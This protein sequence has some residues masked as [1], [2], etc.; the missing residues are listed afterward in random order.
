VVAGEPL[1]SERIAGQRL[2][3]DQRRRSPVH[4]LP[5]LD[6]HR[7]L[8]PRQ[9]TEGIAFACKPIADHLNNKVR[10]LCRTAFYGPV[11]LASSALT[12]AGE[13]PGKPCSYQ[14]L[15][16]AYA[17]FAIGT[18]GL[19]AQQHA[20][21]F[22]SEFASRYPDYYAPEVFGDAAHMQARAV[23]YF[24]PGQAAVIFPG[25]PP[26]TSERLAALGRVIGPQF[27]RQQ[28]R[29]MRTFTDFTCDTTV[30]FGVSLMMFDGHPT[31]FGGK[32][33]LLFGVDIIALLHDPADMPAFFDHELFH[34][35]HRQ[36]IGAR[37]PE[38][39][40]PAWWTMWTEGLATYVSQRMNPGLDAQQVFWYPRDMVVR[41]NQDRARAARLML[42]D[43][44]KTG[45]DAD[46]WFLASDSVDGLPIRAGYYLGYL[47]AKSEG[48]GQPLP[49]LARAT[50]E[51][52]HRAALAFLTELAEGGAAEAG[53][54]AN[55]GAY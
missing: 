52:I 20:A 50:P 9:R 30:E 31:E 4:P 1:E 14:D 23:R 37:A 51:L 54:P 3:F 29:F 43:I 26:L 10:R 18:A 40:Y 12:V 16:P 21:A 5:E 36:V 6:Y 11:M 46:R 47:F 13:A 2:V 44:D 33:Y 19:P 42:R 45:P 25:V 48:D 41:M 49:Q 8:H 17:K 34:L 24:D 28:R 39:D 32:H 55:R 38:G 22:V 15:M 53:H 7:A 27:A 35:Y